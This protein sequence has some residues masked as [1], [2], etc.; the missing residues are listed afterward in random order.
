MHVKSHP[1]VSVLVVLLALFLLIAPMF[2]GCSKKE[3]PAP[4]PAKELP[5]VNTPPQMVNQCV[6]Q[7]DNF[8]CADLCKKPGNAK[9]KWCQ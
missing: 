1:S 8:Y 3:E 5:H 9:L 4:P 2:V 7:P 6:A